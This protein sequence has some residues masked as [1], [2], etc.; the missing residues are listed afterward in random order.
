MFIM[1]SVALDKLL[2]SLTETGDVGFERNV[3]L[4]DGVLIMDVL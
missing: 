1:S 3:H 2:K 4:G